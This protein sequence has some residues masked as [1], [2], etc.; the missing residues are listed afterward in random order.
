MVKQLFESHLDVSNLERSMAFYESAVGLEL[1]VKEG[2]RRIAFYWV[3]GPMK[4]ML[5]LW[6]ERHAPIPPRHI[7][8]EVDL[9]DLEPAIARLSQLGIVTKDFFGRSG[10]EPTVLAWM[11]AVSIYFD[12]PDGHL[13]ELIARLPGDPQ[14]GRGILPWSEWKRGDVVER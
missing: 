9:E 4:T 6:E 1:G 8:F 7:A 2:D 5:G 14:P 10:A 3:G 13:L 11:P 12:D